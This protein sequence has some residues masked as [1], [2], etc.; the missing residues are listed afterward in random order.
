MASPSSDTT[1]ARLPLTA[2]VLLA[3]IWFSHWLPFIFPSARLW[4]I[5]HLLFLPLWARIGYAVG[6]GVL[7]SFFLPSLRKIYTTIYGRLADS[8]FK[9]QAPIRWAI[10]ALASVALFWLLK[11]SVFFLGDSYSVAANI[12]NDIPVI[13]KWSEIG[14]IFTAGTLAHLFPHSSFETGRLVYAIISVMAGGFS[15]YLMF[16]LAN[17]LGESNRQRLFIWSVMV[18][19]GWM[20][21]FFGYT[22]NYPIL[23][24]FFLAF[25]YTSVKYL[26]G[27]GRLIG[28]VLFLMLS[29]VMHLQVLF[30]LASFL[31]IL[32]AR[33]KGARFYYQN[34]AA[35]WGGI[36]IIAGAAIFSAIKIFT[37]SLEFQL[38]LIPLFTPRPPVFDY[39]LFS[40]AHAMDI[41][42]QL[43]LISP[44]LPVLIAA[45][46]MGWKSLLASKIDYFFGLLTIG[47]IAF[48]FII[49]PKLGMGRDWDLFALA[50][51]APTIW[52]LARAVDRIPES[53][54]GMISVS[55]LIL[56]LPFTITQLKTQPA[57][58]N[59]TYLL[60]LDISRART[61]LILLMDY[62]RDNNRA[63]SADSLDLV[64]KRSFPEYTLVPMA[65][66]Y[67]EAGN[68]RE[69]SRIADS[70]SKINPYSNEV[71]NLRGNLYLSTGQYDKAISDFKIAAALGR[72]DAKMLAALASAYNFERNFAK[73]LDILRDAQKRNPDSFDVNETFAT[74]YFGMGGYD[75]ALAYSQKCIQLDANAANAYMMAGFCAYRM[76][77]ND[78]A[79]QYLETFLDK[80]PQSALRD[81]VEKTLSSLR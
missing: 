13:Y 50:F 72:Y 71:L 70:L 53:W 56:V 27:K 45:A 47:G 81:H 25:V 46:W 59:Y 21:L 26:K 32:F 48:L 65:Y 17:L 74:S 42:N 4:G 1:S 64:L 20:V 35:V 31:I 62:Y 30:F 3:A 14:A 54:Y 75:S 67:M 23:W 44:L 7:L 24:P 60:G 79:R 22:E 15:V 73:A 49:D 58:D 19:A 77:R 51:L 57:L 55:A 9:G 52:M 33:G 29:L 11:P 37:N 6:G 12:G 18:L 10:I 80:D 8:V 34:K 40:L 28:P 38:S 43:L 78:L 5:N 2:I 69:A 41:A 16:A 36:L 39:R 61:G 63:A 68:V 66:S 76:R